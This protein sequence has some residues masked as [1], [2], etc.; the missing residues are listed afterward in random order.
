[1]PTTT[2]SPIKFATVHFRKV[3]PEPYGVPMSEPLT[4]GIESIDCECEACGHAWAATESFHGGPA[5]TFA[6][7]ELGVY[8]TCPSCGVEGIWKGG[9]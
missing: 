6:V 8:V 9:R 1:M 7:G 3:D 4:I 5:G 2:A